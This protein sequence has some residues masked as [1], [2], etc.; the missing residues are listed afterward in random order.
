MPM[1]S[2]RR[3]HHVVD[4][5]EATEVDELVRDWLTEAYRDFG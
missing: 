5:V 4:L 3:I 1:R 2:G